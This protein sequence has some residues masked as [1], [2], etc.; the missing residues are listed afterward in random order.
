MPLRERREETYGVILVRVGLVEALL[1]LGI[2]TLGSRI[3]TVIVVNTSRSLLVVASDAGLLLG[4][5]AVLEG[6]LVVVLHG[7]S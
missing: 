5:V 3:R 4:I 1:G 6:S 7:Q 2:G